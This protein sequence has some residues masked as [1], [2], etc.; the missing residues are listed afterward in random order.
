[1]VSEEDMS[2]GGLRYL[3]EC[4][5]ECE[6]LDY[7]EELHLD[8]DYGKA[9]FARD[10]L[11]MKNVGG[12]YIIVGV[13]DKTWKPVGLKQKIGLD[14]KSL[15]DVIRSATGLEIDIYITEPNILLYGENRDFALILIRGTAKATKKRTPSICKVGFHTKETWG[16]RDGDIYFRKGDETVRLH[17]VDE[18]EQLLF[19]LKEVENESVLEQ[20]LVEPSPFLV[21]NGLYR[22]LRSEYETF[23]DRPMLQTEAKKLIEGDFRIWI[24]NVYGPGG[25]GK[26]ALVSWLAYH[27]YENS[28]FDAILH[29]SAKD[30]QLTT[31]GINSLRPTLYSLENLL[32]NILYLFEFS[33]YVSEDLE[34]KKD[35]AYKLLTDYSTLLILDN[36]ETVRDG[37][38]MQ[39]VNSFPPENKSKVLITSRVRSSNWEKPLQVS[40]LSFEEIKQFINVKSQEKRLGLFKNIDNVAKRIQDASGGLPLAIE[41]I[42]GKYALTGNLNAAIEQVPD[43]SSPLLEFSFNSSWK[44]LSSSS[45]KALAVLSIFDEPPTL[46]LWATTLEWTVDRLEPS[47][48]QLIEAALVSLKIDEKTG[49]ST[50]HMLPIT[51]AFARNK[52]ASMGDL[53]LSSMTVYKRHLQQMDLVAVEIQPFNSLF[54][55]FNVTRDTEKQAI[56]LARKAQSKVGSF[57]FD[58]NE[59]EQLFRQALDIDPRSVYVLVNY[60]LFKRELSQV[61]EA[62]NLIERAIPYVNGNNGFYVYYNLSQT[63][64]KV[65]D[66]SRVEQYLRKALEYQ[67]DHIVARHQLGVLLSRLGK[68]NE[69]LAIFDKLIEDEL[70]RDSGPTDTLLYT[71]KTKIITYKKMNRTNEAE[72]VIKVASI[73]LQK[74]PYLSSKIYQLEEA[75]R[76]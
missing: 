9:S 27:Y 57:N 30:T 14:T 33:E 65:R 15:R 55:S 70:A 47:A 50:Y 4:R 56:V 5:A 43:P 36:M 16:I 45:Q 39:F 1:M 68:Y 28:T 44:A 12:G 61:R 76:D 59:A 48:N 67:P 64:D 19:D 63:Y 10:V 73:E 72:E 37:R 34:E 53:E 6:Y 32:D 42:L 69:A 40:E 2:V 35:I 17:S 22:L 7:K 8:N 66:R 3:L 24:I 46:Y 62:I 21:E 49:K 13:E 60:G 38:I 58:Y 54:E 18:I 20:Q 52:L 75:V 31:S 26:S 29:L 71:W 51:K 25:V 74:W 41:W 11:A 23:I